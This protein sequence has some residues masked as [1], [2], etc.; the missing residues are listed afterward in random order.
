MRSLIMATICRL[1]AVLLASLF[2]GAAHGQ[3][4][5]TYHGDPSRSGRYVV[6]ALTWA[7]ARA[8]HLDRGFAPR[9]SGH[10]YAQPLYW[11]PPGAAAGLLIV[12]TENDIVAAFD[13]ASGRTVW[14]RRLGS[15]VP[16]SG[17]PCG[18]IDP[19]GITGTPVIDALSQTLYLDA[20]VNLPS[21]PHHRIF[22]LSL[23]DGT[24]R[25]GWPVDVG[26]ALKNHRVLFN[27]PDQNQRGALA[28][29]GGRV[30]VPFGGHTGDCGDYHGWVVGVGLQNPSDIVAW[31]TTARKGGIW[32][33]GGIASDGARLI[34]ATG[35][36]AGAM[37]WGGGEAVFRL[38]P[39][40]A[41]SGRTQDFFAAKNWP[42]LDAGDV[43]L[44]ATAPL[45]LD[46]PTGRR[47]QRLVLALGKDARAYLLDRDDLGGI[48]GALLSEPVAMHSIGTAPA[49]FPAADGVMVA[50]WGAGT[51]CPVQRPNDALTVLKVR[52][53]VPPKLATTWCGA[54]SGLGAPMV[55]TT[56]GRSNPIVWILGAEGDNRLHGFRGD[57]GATL[58]GGGGPADLL[59][60]LHHFQTLIATHDRLYVGADG[61]V[62]AFSF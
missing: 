10:L 56:D 3:S 52:A 26:A 44:G 30:F 62:Y 24:A 47:V 37:R 45:P 19:V 41:Q 54:L 32:A 5:L 57:T 58:F 46:V 15:P 29:L 4:V 35:N 12:A 16:R 49:A 7:R 53:G 60:G 25:P 43:D 23:E 36:T 31:S 55:T 50:F 1:A 48:G 33:Q 40:L 27:A 28:I 20:M 2:A 22:A 59:T 42:A 38:G 6:P 11:R 17:L 13:T 34:F 8:L 61:R 18:D 14:T 9:F 51:R 21:G 39:D